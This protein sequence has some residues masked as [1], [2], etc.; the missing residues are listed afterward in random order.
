MRY[1]FIV[2]FGNREGKRGQHKGL[3][4]REQCGQNVLEMESGGW[5]WEVGDRYERDE[6][7]AGETHRDMRR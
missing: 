3:T 7:T 1:I 4:K 6:M 5:R 2:V